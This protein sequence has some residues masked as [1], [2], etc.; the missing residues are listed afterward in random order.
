[1]GKG[2]PKTGK[3]SYVMRGKVGIGLPPLKKSLV[4]I[5]SKGTVTKGINEVGENFS[6]KDLQLAHALIVSSSV[7]Q[8]V[9]DQMDTRTIRSE[10]VKAA[11]TVVIKFTEDLTENSFKHDKIKGSTYI[12]DLTN[13]FMKM[14]KDNFE[15]I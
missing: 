1:M 6:I 8:E 14:I 9:L 7:V 15:I 4:Y 12:Q 13:K 2:N 11:L 3:T 10:E 5:N